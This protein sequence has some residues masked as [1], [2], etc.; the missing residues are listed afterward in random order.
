[1]ASIQLESSHLSKN[2]DFS[3]QKMCTEVFEMHTTD[4]N[5]ICSDIQRCEFQGPQTRQNSGVGEGVLQRL[6]MPHLMGPFLKRS[7]F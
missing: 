1:M 3:S 7:T 4:I 6:Q 2:V 5:R